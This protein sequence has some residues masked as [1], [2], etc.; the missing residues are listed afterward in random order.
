MEMLAVDAWKPAWERWTSFG[1]SRAAA[2]Q[3]DALASTRPIE[4]TVRAPDEAA[5]MFDI[6]T[7]EKGAAVLRMLEQYLGSEQFRRGIA[8]Y[9]RQHE[10][11][12]TETSDLW[13]ASKRQPASPLRA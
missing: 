4:Y 5:G 9:L 13:D 2:F 12:N 3:T 7:Y 1:V 10:Y 8:L 11:G 6:L